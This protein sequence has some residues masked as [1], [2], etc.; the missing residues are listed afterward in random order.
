MR[1]LPRWRFVRGRIH[2]KDWTRVRLASGGPL[3]SPEPSPLPEPLRVERRST[4]ATLISA[5]IGRARRTPV[6][7]RDEQRGYV[8]SPLRI[9][10]ELGEH[11]RRP[12]RSTSLTVHEGGRSP[13]SLRHCSGSLQG[14]STCGSGSWSAAIVGQP[15]IQS[16]RRRRSCSSSSRA[17]ASAGP[18][19]S[20]ADSGWGPVSS[21]GTSASASG[22]P[23]RRSSMKRTCCVL[24]VAASQPDR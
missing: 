10:R 20:A 15:A 14:A 23:S 18:T 4:R 19:R 3:G 22:D 2:G 9:A 7:R 11:A 17:R 12:A 5:R 13:I 21:R 16:S 24:N 6:G 8:S 1:L